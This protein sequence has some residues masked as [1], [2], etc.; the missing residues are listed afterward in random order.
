MSLYR[1]IS[2]QFW[3]D[4]KVVDTY[5]PDDKFFWLY[6][7]SNPQTNLIGCY[8][9][10]FSLVAFQMGWAKEKVYEYIVRFCEVHKVIGYNE[11]TQEIIVF[12]WSRYNWTKSPKLLISVGNQLRLVKFDD[13]KQYLVDL[14]NSTNTVS[15]PYGYRRHTVA[16]LIFKDLSVILNPYVHR[17]DTTIQGTTEERPQERSKEQETELAKQIEVAQTKWVEDDE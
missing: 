8:Q 16:N 9:L 6:L 1:P 11:E 12:N 5:T 3:T 13:Y 10:P 14:I 2:T 4:S 17:Q 7:L 15:I